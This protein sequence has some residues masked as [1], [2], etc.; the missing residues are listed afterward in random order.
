MCRDRDGLI[1][2]TTTYTHLPDGTTVLRVEEVMERERQYDDEPTSIAAAHP[3]TWLRR[4][5][6]TCD[7]DGCRLRSRI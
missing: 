3:E 7:R 5:T 2:R 6:L 1:R 4:V